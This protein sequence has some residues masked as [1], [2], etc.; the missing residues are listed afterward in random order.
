MRLLQKSE[1]V[2]EIFVF[3]FTHL[4]N[5]KVYFYSASY[6]ELLQKDVLTRVF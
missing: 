5:D 1:E 3:S 4:Q 2:R 6:E